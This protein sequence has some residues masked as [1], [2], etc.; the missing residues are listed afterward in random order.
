M[1][2]DMF[3]H[4]TGLTPELTE[5]WYHPVMVSMESCGIDTPI[6]QAYFLAQIGVESGGFKFLEE[7]FNYSVEGLL[8][9]GSRITDKQRAEYGRKPGEAVLSKERQATIADLVYGGRYG[10]NSPNDGWKY[11]GRGLKQ[12]TFR[13]NYIACGEALGIDLE[14]NPDLLLEDINAACSAGWF[15]KSN[16]CNS[17]ADKRDL[18]GLTRRINGG[19]NG[20]Q[21]RIEK[22]QKALLALC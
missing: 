12:I 9:F 3:M 21:E 1:T 20:L 5:R 4:A 17:F 19:F 8:I 14:N 16:N 10:N 2:K 13:W 22:T 7:S 18:K 15:W 6:R 11:R